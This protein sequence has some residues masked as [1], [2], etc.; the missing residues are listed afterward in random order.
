MAVSTVRATTRQLMRKVSISQT[1]AYHGDDHYPDD[2]VIAKTVLN[3][4]RVDIPIRTCRQRG[5][6]LIRCND[7]W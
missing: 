2:T 5:N 3:S 6:L 1:S 7:G 4:Y